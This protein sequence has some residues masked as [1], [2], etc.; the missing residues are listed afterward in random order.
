MLQC[1]STKSPSATSSLPASPPAIDVNGYPLGS[2]GNSTEGSPGASIEPAPNLTQEYSNTVQTNS[3]NEMW[4]KIHVLDPNNINHHNHDHDEVQMQIEHINGNEDSHQLLVSQVLQPNRECVDEALRHARPNTLTRLVSTYF[5]HSEN[6]TNLCLLLHQSIYRARELYAALYELFDIF[7]SDHHSLSQLQCDKAF[8]VF[9]QFDSIDN[10]F[11]CPNSH[12]FHEMRRCFSELKQQLDRKL[13]KSHSR[14]RFFSRATSG[15]TLCVIGTAVA[16][17]IA[18]AAVA[19]HALV[20]IVAAPFCTAYF[21]P[22]LAKKQLA[23]VAQLDA[24]KKGIYVLNNDLDTIDRLVA[25]LYT[26]VEG[27]KQ[28]VRFGLERGRDKHSIQEVV[29]QLRRNQQNFTDQLKDLEE[30]ICL[31]FNTVNRARSLLL[32][33]IHL[34]QN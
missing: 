4:S 12:N 27:D 7:P 1:L 25:R 33:E 14:V 11:P 30:H 28:L 32:Q 15:S 17:T 19:T 31:C 22:G 23:H 13:R 26:A 3:Y 29:K 9:L 34:H 24:A 5:D 20:A 2:Q 16:V 8:E 21:S 6:T 18:A 10:P